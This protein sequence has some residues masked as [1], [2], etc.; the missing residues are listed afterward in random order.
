MSLG[1]VIVAG[2]VIT[3]AT[4]KHGDDA[5]SNDPGCKEYSSQLTGFLTTPPTGY[6]D[7]EDYAKYY[8]AYYFPAAYAVDHAQNDQVTR[9]MIALRDASQAVE[10]DA[11]K[12]EVVGG[13]T[14]VSQSTLQADISTFDGDR[15]AVDQICALN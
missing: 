10:S 11:T 6:T 4:V 3:V 14:P 9:A 12:D 7:Y 5:V 15:A 8:G 13:G 2:V 1:V